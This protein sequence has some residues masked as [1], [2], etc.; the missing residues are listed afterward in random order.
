MADTKTDLWLISRSGPDSEVMS[1]PRVVRTSLA[2]PSSL[3][4]RFYIPLKATGSASGSNFASARE[5]W[6]LCWDSNGSVDDEDYAFQH[7]HD[8][9]V[10]FVRLADITSPPVETPHDSSWDEVKGC[11]PR[12]LLEQAS[13][14]YV[15]SCQTRK[16][17]DN[18]A[19]R[20]RGVR[21][22]FQKYSGRSRRYACSHDGDF[23]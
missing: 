20:F 18:M 19:R 3:V 2:A 1:L 8:N 17:K 13:S 14:L 4:Y 7:S 9:K 23:S 15:W 11:L 22:K 21:A 6:T 5:Y 12:S 16:I 10:A